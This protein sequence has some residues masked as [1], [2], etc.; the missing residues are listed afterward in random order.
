LVSS[1][2]KFGLSL[3]TAMIESKLMT[4]EEIADKAAKTAVADT[5][6]K[7]QEF[8]RD[9]MKVMREY[10]DTRFESSERSIN[11]R[12]DAVD[13]RFAVVNNRFDRVDDTLENLEGRLDRV[14]SALTT[15]LEEF[16]AHREKV[17]ALETEISLLRSRLDALEAKVGV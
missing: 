9:E 11:E 10:I 13:S 15:L 12:F 7:M 14:E 3:I 1:L 5:V 6:A 2:S 16:K 8:H 17:V 4:H